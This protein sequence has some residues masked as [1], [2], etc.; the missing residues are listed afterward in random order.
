M[1]LVLVYLFMIITAI[2]SF[3][4]V[5][6]P[7]NDSITRISGG[8]NKASIGLVSGYKIKSGGNE[9][10]DENKTIAKMSDTAAVRVCRQLSYDMKEL[11]RSGN[12]ACSGYEDS[13]ILFKFVGTAG[14]SGSIDTLYSQTKASTL[15]C[16]T[17][18]QYGRYLFSRALPQSMVA[19]KNV[20]YNLTNVS[21]GKSDPCGFKEIIF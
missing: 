9:L 12:L 2:T 8:Y 20:K 5:T 7:K 17:P 10:L 4:L 19:G 16:A 15:S 1:A 18:E 3:Q 11:Y 21:I 13:T 14:A 6:V